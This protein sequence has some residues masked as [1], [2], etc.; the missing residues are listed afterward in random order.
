MS[1]ADKALRDI[2]E[3]VLQA[4][5]G[6]AEGKTIDFKQER[7]GAGDGDRK[8]F[9]YDVSS[10]ANTIGGDLLFGVAEKDDLASAVPGLYGI[11]PE[12]EIL[13]LEQMARDGIRPPIA[14][15]A[16]RAVPLTNGGFALVMRIPRSWAGPHQVTY[17]K[18]FRFYARD[19]NGKYPVDVDGLRVAFVSTSALADQL[20][21]FRA[22]RMAKLQ[23]GAPPA[24][25]QPGAK[26]MLHVVPYSAAA[27]GAP[28]ALVA[29][30]TD[31]RYFPTWTDRGGR[32]VAV[33]FD[34]LLATSNAN[35]LPAAQRAY[36]LVTRTG[37]VEAV[38]TI[39]TFEPLP[40]LQAQIAKHAY[41]YAH[42]LN[43]LGTP[44]PFAVFASF[45]ACRDLRLLHDFNEHR[46]IPEDLPCGIL[47]EDQYAPVETIWETLPLTITEAATRLKNTLDHIAN[48][49]GLSAA[50]YFDENG[51]YELDL[52]KP[53]GR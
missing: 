1:L 31:S 36:T 32:N 38:A 34:G 37:A 4:L 45:V 52:D 26:I 51:A 10:F 49:A 30:E 53:P 43:Q 21:S 40:A 28:F 35:P 6:E 29:A 11:N 48:A 8:E 2:D 47:S 42:S 39:H 15:I 12:Q 50:P 25:L 16:S 33:T 18:A 19:T 3:T 9:L 44:P 14:G 5:I 17:Q 22:E 41:R 13:R 27:A 20:R 46:A 7:V 24:P 23:S